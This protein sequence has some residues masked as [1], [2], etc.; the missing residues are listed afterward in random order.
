[1]VLLA[2]SVGVVGCVA[3]RVYHMCTLVYLKKMAGLQKLVV[4]GRVGNMER[5]IINKKDLTEL[6]KAKR[7][8]A[9]IDRKKRIR[10]IQAAFS[11]LKADYS[12]GSSVEYVTNL[13]KKWRA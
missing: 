12:K 13:R 3:A 5:F 6:M 10:F 1:M 2:V 9:T 11:A 4:F 7:R 8:L